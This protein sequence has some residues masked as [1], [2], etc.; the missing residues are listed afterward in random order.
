MLKTFDV[1]DGS[2]TEKHF[3][4]ERKQHQRVIH[5]SMSSALNAS[6]WGADEAVE[7]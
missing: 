3:D 4:F 1:I 5:I 7:A 2:S 6:R